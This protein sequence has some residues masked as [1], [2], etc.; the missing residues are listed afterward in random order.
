[1]I[2]LMPLFGGNAITKQVN[3]MI[4]RGEKEKCG[5]HPRYQTISDEIRQIYQTATIEEIVE[6][7]HYLEHCID[8]PSA[9]FTNLVLA[10]ISWSLIELF[11]PLLV[12]LELASIYTYAIKI[13]A[14][15]AFSMIYSFFI[16]AICTPNDRLY[17]SYDLKDMELALIN[18]IL[19]HELH[20][21]W[22]ADQIVESRHPN[23]AAEPNKSV[24]AQLEQPE[25]PE[26]QESL[27]S[28]EQDDLHNSATDT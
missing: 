25:T 7:K 10:V 23:K 27:E 15:V 3:R 2:R 19:E 24:A 14:I 4:K 20:N 13:V 11:S 16:A 26:P 21:D 6:R 9:I 12:G 18:A 28:S 8:Y 5:F 22:T 17:L 1:M